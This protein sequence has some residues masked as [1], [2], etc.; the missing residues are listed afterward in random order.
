M[1][2]A[3][4]SAGETKEASAVQSL[5]HLSVFSVFSVPAPEAVGGSVARSTF[6]TATLSI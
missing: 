4:P 6:L 2:K 5:S 1:A 3:E